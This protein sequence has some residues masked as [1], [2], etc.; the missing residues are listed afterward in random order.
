MGELKMYRHFIAG[1][2]GCLSSN[3]FGQVADTTLIP[4]PDVQSRSSLSSQNQ[5][6]GVTGNAGVQGNANLQNNANRPSGQLNS[7]LSTQIQGQSTL[8]GQQRGNNDL[9]DPNRQYGN[10]YQSNGN[11]GNPSQ[12]IQGQGQGLQ[13]GQAWNQGMNSNATPN[14]GTMQNRS[15]TQFRSSSSGSNGQQFWA[16]QNDNCVYLLRFDANGREYIC[17]NGRPV[18]FDNVK[19]VSPQGNSGIQNPYTA[20][21][22]NYELNNGQNVQNSSREANQSRT[23]PSQ[24]QPLG[25]GQNSRDRGNNM[26]TVDPNNARGATTGDNVAIPDRNQNRL[27]NQGD[28]AILQ[29]GVETQNNF[30]SKTEVTKPS[31]TTSDVTPPRL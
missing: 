15:G 4:T 11:N 12:S 5:V 3:L 26:R 8:G 9:Q 16:V 2:L 1:A 23:Q 19:S 6:N 10:T 28:S 31:E 21:Y 22:G 24:Q 13:G 7:N 25:Q 20:G 18:Y 17:V 29:N 30:N 27:N 14:N